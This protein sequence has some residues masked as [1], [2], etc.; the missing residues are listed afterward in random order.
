MDGNVKTNEFCGYIGISD[1]FRYKQVAGVWALLGKCCNGWEW[2][3]VASTNDIGD[4]I[5]EDVSF[6]MKD[7][8]KRGKS[9]KY[10]NYWDEEV[11][12]FKIFNESKRDYYY[13]R[14]KALWSYISSI[15]EEF[16]F[17]CLV[18]NE[19]DEK[20]RL[21]KEKYIALQTKAKYWND[22]DKG[23][24]NEQ[25]EELNAIIKIVNEKYN[26]R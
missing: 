22:L 24:M 8:S 18:E 25:Y 11:F 19:M 7:V 17:V 20:K 2:I 14:R 1:I 3:I 26:I 15:Y 4:E 9:H 21:S 23:N 13:A 5:A 12:E 6:M 16:S 10:I